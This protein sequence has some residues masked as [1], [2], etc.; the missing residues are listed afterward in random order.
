[1]IRL[2]ALVI[3]LFSFSC[4]K[5]STSPT[6]LPAIIDPPA[7]VCNYG[8]YGKNCDSS[9]TTFFAGKYKIYDSCVANRKVGTITTTFKIINTH[10]ANLFDSAAYIWCDNFWG[11]GER[12]QIMFYNKDTLQFLTAPNYFDKKTSKK[13]LMYLTDKPGTT[14]FV[15]NDSCSFGLV[16]NSVINQ[17]GINDYLNIRF[18]KIK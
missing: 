7:K 11:Q 14:M 10:D 6:S 5:E 15:R 18:E 3:V 2:L 9:Y 13:W 8:F 16:Y 17:L 4:K 1:M 12:E